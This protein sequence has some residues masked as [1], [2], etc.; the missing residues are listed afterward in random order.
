MSE[1]DAVQLA[2][3]KQ[4]ANPPMGTDAKIVIGVIATIGLIIFL[5]SFLSRLPNAPSLQAA[6]DR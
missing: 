4:A 3:I 6:I 2:A 1:P 5:G